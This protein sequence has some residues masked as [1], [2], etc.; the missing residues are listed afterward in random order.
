MICSRQSC[1][2]NA[3][4]CQLEVN[5]LKLFEMY[6]QD[7]TVFHVMKFVPCDVVVRPDQS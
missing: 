4:P 6:D 3:G 1:F 7:Q 5:H 2:G